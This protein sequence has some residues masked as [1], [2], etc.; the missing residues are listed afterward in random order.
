MTRFASVPLILAVALGG[1]SLFHKD[2]DRPAFGAE[3]PDQATYL[4][5]T[6]VQPDEGAASGTAVENALAW[7]EKYGQAVEQLARQQ[8]ENRKLADQ[9]R[10]L[11]ANIVS[12]EGE[13][14]QT[15]KELKEANDLLIDVRR[16]NE[17]WKTN[18][19]D[20]RDE[21]RRALKTIIE[22]EIRVVRLL[23]GEVSDSTPT[24]GSA[25]APAPAEGKAEAQSQTA[26][27][28]QGDPGASTE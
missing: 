21:M 16:A 3:P 27:D 4:K 12:L 11:E 22:T 28:S 23:G 17:E 25:E 2:E 19:L 10:G 5:E 8:Q 13:L 26:P 6:A 24:A 14:A 9:N 15:R 1:C 18:V 7:S 20:Y